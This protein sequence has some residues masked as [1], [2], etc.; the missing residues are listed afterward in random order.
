MMSPNP[1]ALATKAAPM[2][3]PAG[4]ERTSFFRG[5]RAAAGMHDLERPHLRRQVGFERFQVG[6]DRRAQRRV[7]RGGAGAF[8]LAELGEDVA[9]EAYG[10]AGGG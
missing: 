7:D 8:V 2:T 9:A 6:L 5:E 1:A 4:P 3:P 10:D